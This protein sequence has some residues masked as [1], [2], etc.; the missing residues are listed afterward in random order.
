MNN[1]NELT[2]SKEIFINYMKEKYPVIHNSN[3]F[4]RDLQY[5]IRSF[6]EKKGSNLSYS[7]TEKIAL[8]F[9]ELME[10]S[11]DFKKIGNNTWKMNFSEKS[12]VTDIE[13]VNN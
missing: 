1:L 2:A 13:T 8:L 12:V 6:F 10:Q 7:E 5:A 9:A 3:I 11:N 4:L